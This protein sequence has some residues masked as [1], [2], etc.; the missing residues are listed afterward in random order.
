MTTFFVYDASPIGSLL[1]VSRGRGLAGLYMEDHA[2]GPSVG[3]DWVQDP[4]KFDDARRQLAEYFAGTRASFDLALDPTGTQFQQRVWSALRDIPYGTTIP[5]AELAR[6]V[7]VDGGARAVGNANAR[8]PIAIVVPCHR[9]IGASGA[10]TGYAGGEARKRWLLE[11][12]RRAAHV[13]RA[14]GGRSAP[15]EALRC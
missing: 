7:G 10:L 14:A 4:A 15:I 1:F 5:Y 12:E 3:P 6:R 13:P 11:H 8:N 2:R 9:V